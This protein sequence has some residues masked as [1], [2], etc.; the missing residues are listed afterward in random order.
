MIATQGFAALGVL[1]PDFVVPN[2]FINTSSGTVDFAGVDNIVY[3]A[4]QLPTDGRKRSHARR[5][6]RAQPRGEFL[7]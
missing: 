5:N 7:R 4:G 1:A 6:Q 3:G 2:N